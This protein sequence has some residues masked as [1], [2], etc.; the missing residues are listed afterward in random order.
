MASGHDFSFA[1]Y[2]TKDHVKIHWSPLPDDNGGLYKIERS[3]DGKM[4]ETIVQARESGN[5]LPS[6]TEFIEADFNPMLGWS[7]YRISY[8][9]KD[10]KESASPLAPV[11]F[12]VDYLHTHK[13]MTASIDTELPFPLY[14]EDVDEQEV[15]LV[16]RNGDGMEFY[17]KTRISLE[18]DAFTVQATQTLLPGLYTVTSSSKDPLVGLTVIA[19]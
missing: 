2:S 4:F 16:L 19:E 17:Y 14:E 10:G 9:G 12:G 5:T 13:N 7:Y 6:G 18:G 11:F 15:V 8:F 3:H 1:V